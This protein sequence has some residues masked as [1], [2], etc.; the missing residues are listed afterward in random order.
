[1]CDIKINAKSLRELC[2]HGTLCLKT[3]YKV[4]V[5]FSVM[6]HQFDETTFR[7]VVCSSL[8]FCAFW[9]LLKEEPVTDSSS[10]VKVSV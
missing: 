5:L 9:P 7:E 10:Q 6:M 1:M 2:L 8:G 4:T 3:E